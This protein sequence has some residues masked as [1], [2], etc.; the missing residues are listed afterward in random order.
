MAIM[1]DMMIIQSILNKIK[2]EGVLTHDRI[3]GENKEP[4]H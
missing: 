1:P 4:D 3:I 2:A